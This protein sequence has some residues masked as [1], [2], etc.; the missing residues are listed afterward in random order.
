MSLIIAVAKSNEAIIGGD[1]RSIVFLGSCPELEQ[2]LYT[3]KL[4]TDEDLL[5]RAKE[6]GASLR[7]SDGREKVWRRGDV[8]V[9]EVTE[10]SSALEKR[11]R[12]Y[13]VPGAYIM[14][15]ITGK[16]SK[17]IGQGK[18]ACMVQGNRFTQEL[19]SQ[20]INN[21]KGKIDKNVLEAVL[22]NVGSRTPSISQEHCVLSTNVKQTKPEA[23]VFSAL[24]ED[25]Q[26]CGWRLCYQ[27]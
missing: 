9:G 14:A 22:A 1:K 10:I 8:L 5:K 16:E 24:R 20:G 15:D 25:W 17:V 3:G 21:S 27:Q 2:E 6:L 4:K 19:A 7:I 23:T 26:K 11:R 13:L 18:V 12:I